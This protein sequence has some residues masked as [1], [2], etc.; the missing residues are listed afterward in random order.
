MSMTRIRGENGSCDKPQNIPI[1]VYL[2]DLENERNC[3]ISRLR[4]IDKTLIDYGRIKS[5]TI[6][7]RMR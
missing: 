5:E 2:K 7:R 6:P 1:D 4:H 3:L